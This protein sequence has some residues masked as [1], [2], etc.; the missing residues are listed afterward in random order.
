MF[1]RFPRRVAL[2]F[3]MVSLCSAA[4]PVSAATDFQLGAYVGNPDNSNPT[5][6][7][8]FERRIQAFGSLVGRKPDIIEG[9]LDNSYPI[10]DSVK[11]NSP[12]VL[13]AAWYVS[14]LNLACSASHL[15]LVDS[16]GRPTI[17]PLYSIPLT[18]RSYLVNGKYNQAAAIAMMNDIA[19]GRYDVDDPANGKHRV[20]PAI[21]DKF[22][23]AGYRKLYLRL[24][25]EQNGNW[26]GWQ[27]RTPAAAAAYVAA[28][29]HVADL[30]HRYATTNGMEIRT[31]WSPLA[32]GVYLP[33]NTPL[34]ASYPGDAYVDVIGPDFYSD[35][36]NATRS[37]DGMAYYDWSTRAKVTLADW[38]A[39]PVNRRHS[40]D[41]PESDFWNPRRGWGLP[42]AIDFALARGK[43]FGLSE[44]G[45][46]GRG[47]ILNGGG[48]TDDGEFPV[49]ILDRLSAAEARGLKV[50]FAVIWAIT[51]NGGNDRW[52]FLDGEGP[53]KAAA[54]AQF[55]A[56][57]SSTSPRTSSVAIPRRTGTSAIV[58]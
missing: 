56:G 34:S 17:T 42:A 24:G 20:W 16:A 47:D 40:W 55:V 49:Y 13:N 15:N 39:N 37:A 21:F 8:L 44:T 2:R 48:P 31:I 36:W 38:Y 12:W 10:W 18:D 22:R 23:N 29:R 6:E 52:G 35:I 33:A 54:W 58:R 32:G 57:I 19:N 41:Y 25:W 7:A 28:W 5:T 50:E 46:G 14:S 53:Q 3:L 1:S 30:A 51:V 43:P 26:Y 4:A 11:Q 9:F 45:A 27:A